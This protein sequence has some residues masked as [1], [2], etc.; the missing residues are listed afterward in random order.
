MSNSNR[1]GRLLGKYRATVINIEDP[2]QRHT[3]QVRVLGL[4]DSVLQADLPW[5]EYLLPVGCRTAE[6]V[7]MPATVGDHVWV[8]FPYAGDTRFPLIIGSCYRIG[9]DDVSELPLD[10]RVGDTNFEHVRA[11][12]LPAAPVPAYGDAVT[13]L[14]GMLRQLTQS[15]EWCMTHKATGTALHITKDGEIVLSGQKNIDLNSQQN[16]VIKAAQNVSIHAEK[17]ATIAAKGNADITADGTIKL[18]GGGD[19]AIKSGGGVAIESTAALELK[20]GGELSLA[21]SLISGKT[22]SMY[23]FK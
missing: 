14:F 9:D 20:A 18:D 22:G 12:G 11:D 23:D 1:T 7:V 13:D 15:G 4:W 3:A 5:A 16:V 8:E 17:D 6:G 10:H 19:V 2:E 21:G